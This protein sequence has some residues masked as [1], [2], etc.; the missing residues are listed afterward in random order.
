MQFHRILHPRVRRPSAG[1]CVSAQLQ[2]VV[3]ELQAQ[4]L[5]QQ[6]FGPRFDAASH[7]R[8]NAQALGNRHGALGIGRRHEDGEAGAH[9][10]CA[11]GLTVVVLRLLLDE[12]QES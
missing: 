6:L 2:R 1:P 10:Q 11:V 3:A 5:D 12:P 8:A 7:T 9:V 4:R